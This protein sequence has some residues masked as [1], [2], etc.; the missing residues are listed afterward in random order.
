[1]RSEYGFLNDP[2]TSVMKS[3]EGSLEE[4]AYR[5]ATCNLLL[6]ISP[7]Q[8]QSGHSADHK[9]Q[10]VVKVIPAISFLSAVIVI[11]VVQTLLFI[12]LYIWNNF[13][14]YIVV[15]MVLGVNR[16]L[17]Y[18]N[19]R[20]TR[21]N[22]LCSSRLFSSLSLLVSL[23][24]KQTTSMLGNFFLTGTGFI[25]SGLLRRLSQIVPEIN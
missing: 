10:Y 13:Y 2:D 18:C 11:V 14:N 15:V 17:C 4:G 20:N 7:S 12:V 19:C 8:T 21:L 23:P 25:F 6:Y 1:M 3:Q 16:P 22:Y 24:Q 9:L 5:S